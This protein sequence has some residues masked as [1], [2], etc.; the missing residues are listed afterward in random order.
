MNQQQKLS[1]IL[2]QA[3]ETH[4]EVYK[5]VEGNDPDWALW[6]AHWLLNLSDFPDILG[7]EMLESELVYLLVKLDK[8]YSQKNPDQ[9]W[10]EYYAMRILNDV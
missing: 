9:K 10:E 3:A 6:Y 8:E 2:H 7:K 5:K 4:H 1:E